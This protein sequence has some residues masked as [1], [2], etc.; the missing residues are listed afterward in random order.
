MKFLIEKAT[1][2]KN[3]NPGTFIYILY[4]GLILM[5]LVKYIKSLSLKSKIKLDKKEYVKPRN[6][7]TYYLSAIIIGFG[8]MNILGKQTLVGILMVT[9]AVLFIITTNEKMFI[10]EDGIFD[11]GTYIKWDEL[12]KW[13][14]D[15]KNSELVLKSKIGYEEKVNYV[16]VKEDDVDEINE[17]I[18]K[19]KLNK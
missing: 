14:F 16:K 7:W 15:L 17:L 13:G 8:F 12:K 6:K 3:Q 19:Y 2:P 10:T 18:R 5:L 11:Q 9:L 4:G 1:E